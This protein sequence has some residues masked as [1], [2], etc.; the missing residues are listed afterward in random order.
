M[1]NQHDTSQAW[2]PAE[3]DLPL[4]NLNRAINLQDGLQELSLAD[5]LGVAPPSIVYSPCHIIHTSY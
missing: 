3:K 4:I 2:R 5:V 1:S